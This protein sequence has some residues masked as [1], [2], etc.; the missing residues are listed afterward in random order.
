MNGESIDMILNADRLVLYVRTGLGCA[1][2][3][4][5]VVGHLVGLL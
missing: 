2:L 1:I 3:G 4:L 5:L